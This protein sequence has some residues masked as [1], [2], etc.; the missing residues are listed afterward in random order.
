MT[1]APGDGSTTV[2]EEVMATKVREISCKTILTRTGGFLDGFTHTLQPYVGCVYRCPY[3]YVQALPVHLYHGG[4]WGDYVDVKT[5]APERLEAEM[6]RLKKRDRAVRVFLSSATDPYQGAESKYRITRQ[7]L[8]VFAAMQP[9]R[10]VV[11]TRSPMVRRDFDVLK[12]IGPAELNVTLETHDEAV[13]RD[14]TPHAPSVAARLKTLDAAMEAGLA[15]RV[16]ISPMLPNDPDTFVE[17]I[18]DRCHSVVVDTYFDGDGSGGMRTER[19]RVRELYQRFGYG[20]WYRLGAYHGLVNALK[21]SLGAGRVA[22]SK[23]GFNRAGRIAWT[24]GRERGGPIG[25]AR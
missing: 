15:V 24:G 23:E 10:L 25:E 8:E 9:D 3:C 6:A 2:S 5:N 21:A 20:E 7:C 17:T 16:T 18:R 12:R 19:L 11:Q 1:G 4:A 13:R 14:L 22:Y